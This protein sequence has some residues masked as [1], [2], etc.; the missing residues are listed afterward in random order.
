MTA[1]K[2]QQTELRPLDLELAAM[3]LRIATATNVIR[4]RDAD[5]TRVELNGD[6]GEIVDRIKA[7][8]QE[9]DQ[10]AARLEAQIA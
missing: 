7:A 2:K 8:A 5:A 10:I 4:T 1:K 3:L 6:R 9:L